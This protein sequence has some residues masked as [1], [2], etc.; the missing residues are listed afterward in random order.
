MS[1]ASRAAALP[2]P[3]CQTLTTIRSN[4]TW[5]LCLA[6]ARALD[7]VEQEAQEQVEVDEAEPVPLAVKLPRALLLRTY[8]LKLRLPE[9][10]QPLL[11]NLPLLH[12]P[13]RRHR[14]HRRPNSALRSNLSAPIQTAAS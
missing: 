6:E 5:A 12:H 11:P 1:A 9:P 14:R 10:P 7:G 13:L 4:R 3:W 2:T 8:L